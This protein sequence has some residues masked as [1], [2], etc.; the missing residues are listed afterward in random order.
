MTITEI[1]RVWP[2]GA[3]LNDSWQSADTKIPLMSS[4]LQ[5]VRLDAMLSLDV[6]QLWRGRLVG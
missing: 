6:L 5:L 3:S 4:P 1:G 2:P